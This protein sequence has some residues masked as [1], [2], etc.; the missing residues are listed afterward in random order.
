VISFF[1]TAARNTQADSTAYTNQ[2]LGQ[3]AAITSGQVPPSASPGQRDQ[4]RRQMLEQAAA[5]AVKAG[6]RLVLVVDGLDEDLRV[7]ARLRA[8]Q[9]GR[10]P[11]LLAG[12]RSDGAQGRAGW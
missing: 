11:A 4:L 5:R 2:L 7:P 6:L 12:N 3:L 8:R 9:H 1:V 10:L